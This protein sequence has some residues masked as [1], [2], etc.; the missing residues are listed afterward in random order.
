MNR[1]AKA[2]TS[3]KKNKTNKRVGGDNTSTSGQPYGSKTQISDLSRFVL[4]PYAVKIKHRTTV[5]ATLYSAGASS[6]SR[7][8]NANGLYDFDPR[9][10]GSSIKGFNQWMGLYLQYQVISIRVVGEFVNLESQPM[11]VFVHAHGNPIADNALTKE[12]TGYRF[13]KDCGML[14]AKGGMDRA[15]FAF[16]IDLEDLV[17]NQTYWGDVAYFQGIATANPAQAIQ[18]AVGAQTTT[19]VMAVGGVLCSLAVEFTVLYSNGVDPS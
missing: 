14:S 10:G 7:S 1:R 15:K 4:Q 19:G 2:K 16:N 9:V 11:N 18:F 13:S 5:L 12:S 17:G 3:V 8:W 6:Q